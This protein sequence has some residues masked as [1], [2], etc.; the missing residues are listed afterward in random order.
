MIQTQILYEENHIEPSMWKITPEIVYL[1][2]SLRTDGYYSLKNREAGIQNKNLPFL[3]YIEDILKQNKINFGKRL[4]IKVKIPEFEKEDVKLLQ[5]EKEIRFHIEK[6]PF[7]G[8]KK[9]AFNLPS[10]SQNLDI[11]IKEDIFPLS[12][13]VGDEEILTKC[14]FL[15]FGYSEIRF[16]NIKFLRFLDSLKEI[17]TKNTEFII[18]AFGALIDAEGMLEHRGFYRKIRIRMKDKSYLE[19]WKVILKSFD[20]N[21]N[22]GRDEKGL[23]KLEIYGWED[24]DKLIRMGLRFRHSKKIKKFDVIMKSFKRN[25]VSRNTGKEFYLK[26]LREISRPITSEELSKITNKSKRNVNHFLLLLERNEK[27]I[28]DK[29]KIPYVYTAK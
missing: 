16:H 4:L 17:K 20:I 29:N 15:S 27:L 26:K 19:N 9:I 3:R 11:K 21:S 12:V 24:F 8:S 28:V 25:Q 22:F 23:Y 1:I 14:E 7:D 10:N 13:I 6:S 2:E 18:S 5:N